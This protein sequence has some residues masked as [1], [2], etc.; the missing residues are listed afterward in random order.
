MRYGHGW[1][2]RQSTLVSAH[3]SAV[4]LPPKEKS[5]L[6]YQKEAAFPIFPTVS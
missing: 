5:R 1:A 4:F 2:A 3:F 6:F